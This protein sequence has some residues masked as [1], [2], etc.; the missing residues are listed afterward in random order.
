MSLELFKDRTFCINLKERTDR[1][2]VVSEDLRKVGLLPYTEFY[3]S[4]RSKVSGAVGCWTSHISVMRLARDRGLDWVLVFEDDLL[5]EEDLMKRNLDK[6]LAFL[7]EFL[8]RTDWGTIFLGHAP[9]AAEAPIHTDGDFRVYRTCTT[10]AHAYIANLK[11]DDIKK[12]INVPLPTVD[13]IQNAKSIYHIDQTFADQTVQ[14]AI[15]PMFVF[16]RPEAGSDNDWGYAELF[17]SQ[18]TPEACRNH[19]EL[20]I[21]YPMPIFKYQLLNAVPHVL[22]RLAPQLV[23]GKFMLYKI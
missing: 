13:V 10:L 16:Q 22:F 11:C 19:E 20:V 3:H 15:Y 17:R 23:F 4:E 5:F 1:L 6:L 12:I 7:P 9:V 18:N 2:E 21:R 8:K 14:Y